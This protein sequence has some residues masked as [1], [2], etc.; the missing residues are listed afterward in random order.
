[1]LRQIYW[2]LVNTAGLYFTRLQLLIHY[3]YYPLSYLVYFNN[4]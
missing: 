4:N 1:M 3:F 2:G